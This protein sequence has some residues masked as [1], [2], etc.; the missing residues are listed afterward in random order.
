MQAAEIA[1]VFAARSQLALDFGRSEAEAA[2]VQGYAALSRLGFGAGGFPGIAPV[3]G[4]P[5]RA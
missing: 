1:R 3:G 2:R 5:R 4:Q